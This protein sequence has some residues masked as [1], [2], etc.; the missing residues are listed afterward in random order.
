[1]S[2]VNPERADLEI[3]NESPDKKYELIAGKAFNYY[4]TKVKI[5]FNNRRRM[6]TLWVFI[7]FDTIY[8][9]EISKNDYIFLLRAKGINKT[10]IEP[11][12]IYTKD[13]KEFRIV[14]RKDLYADQMFALKHYFSIVSNY[15]NKNELFKNA[16]YSGDTVRLYSK[17]IQEYLRKTN[18]LKIKVGGVEVIQW[19]AMEKKTEN[20]E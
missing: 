17:D 13:I 8:L 4:L 14:K 2:I 9:N 1:M 10:H 19:L 18:S 7:Y 20:N 16:E 15:R 11:Y 6:K 3:L 12:I 5:R